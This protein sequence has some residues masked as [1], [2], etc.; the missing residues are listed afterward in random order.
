[1]TN[2]ARGHRGHCV[3]ARRSGLRPR[4]RAETALRGNP[5]RGNPGRGNPGRSNP[6][7]SNSG[8]GN[9]GRSNP[10]RGNPGRSNP[11]RS[12]PGRGYIKHTFAHHRVTKALQRSDKACAAVL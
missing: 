1:M 5:G 8:R 7:R 9:P 12:N 2:E 6:G 10:G 3:L 4:S 11:G